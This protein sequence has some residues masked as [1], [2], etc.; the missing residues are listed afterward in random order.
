MEKL[1]FFAR[2]ICKACDVDPDQ[3]SVGLGNLIPEGQRYPLWQ[4]YKRQ[5]AAAIA[6][7]RSWQL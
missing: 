2:E 5:A 4:A 3:V 7:A 1:E 6:A